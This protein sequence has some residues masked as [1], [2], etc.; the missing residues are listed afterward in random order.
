ME[1]QPLDDQPSSSR[2]AWAGGREL[3]GIGLSVV[4]RCK[5][6]PESGYL[7]L[8]GTAVHSV[9][10]QARLESLIS[11]HCTLG[12]YQQTGGSHAEGLCEL[13]EDC[14]RQPEPFVPAAEEL[15]VH[16]GGHEEA[17]KFLDAS[18]GDGPYVFSYRCIWTASPSLRGSY[19]AFSNALSVLSHTQTWEWVSNPFF[20]PLVKCQ[21]C[22]WLY[23]TE[24]SQI[25]IIFL[26]SSCFLPHKRRKPIS[27]QSRCLTGTPWRLKAFLLSA[28]HPYS[29]WLPYS[30]SSIAADIQL[31]R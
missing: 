17:Q 31:S 11:E 22:I 10:V 4:S 28:C 29:V 27:W 19:Y 1:S 2:R 25:A 24:K 5:W 6:G 26:K 14:L 18:Q 12:D 3:E 8:P 9:G 30:W 7:P 15:W 20:M 23:V 13:S 16:Q 21:N